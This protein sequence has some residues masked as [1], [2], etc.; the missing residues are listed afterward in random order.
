MTTA[1]ESKSKYLALHTGPHGPI[2]AE[3]EADDLDDAVRV[4]DANRSDWYDAAR[5][6][7]TIDH[8]DPFIGSDGIVPDDLEVAIEVALS[9]AGW[10][11]AL[12]AEHSGDYEIYCQAE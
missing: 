9:A 1:T 11:H 3:F 6:D 7:L 8:D 2:S 4:K 5:D 10:V 12:H